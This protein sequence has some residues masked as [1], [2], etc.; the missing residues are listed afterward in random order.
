MGK[1][2]ELR[3]DGGYMYITDQYSVLVYDIKT[4]KL[5]KRLGNKG[6]G[7]NN[8]PGTLSYQHKDMIDAQIEASRNPRRSRK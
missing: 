1:P 7:R 5:V 3:I 4:F 2:Y 8:L 6:E